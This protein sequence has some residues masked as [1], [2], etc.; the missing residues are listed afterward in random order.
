M[1]AAA[2]VVIFG[3]AVLFAIVARCADSMPEPKQPIGQDGP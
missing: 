1:I 3:L 2:F